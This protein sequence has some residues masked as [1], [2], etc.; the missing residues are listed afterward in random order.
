[1]AVD[2][3]VRLLQPGS[4]VENYAVDGLGRIGNAAA[5][6]ALEAAQDQPDGDVRAAARS[7]LRALQRNAQPSATKN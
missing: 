5:I 3:L 4:L 7:M 6:A 2:S 1:L